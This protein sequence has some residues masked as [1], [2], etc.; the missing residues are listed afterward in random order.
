MTKRAAAPRPR[1]GMHINSRRPLTATR[2]ELELWDRAV[3]HAQDDSWA[4]WAR[5]V[6]TIAAADELGIDPLEALQSV[7]AAE[8]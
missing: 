2:A 8:R 4:E 5:D 6:L 3:E 1:S 7:R